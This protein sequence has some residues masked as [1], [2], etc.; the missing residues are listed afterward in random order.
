MRTAKK[1]GVLHYI[2][3][4]QFEHKMG[5]DLVYTIFLSSTVKKKTKKR[6]EYFSTLESVP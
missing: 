4:R 6:L 5:F 1:E 3:L 2:V